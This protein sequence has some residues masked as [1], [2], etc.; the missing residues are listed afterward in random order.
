M[1]ATTPVSGIL[2]PTSKPNTRMAPVNP[3]KTPTHC[4]IETYSFNKGPLKA[5]VRTG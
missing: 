1:V 4:L 3:S 2:V 5:L